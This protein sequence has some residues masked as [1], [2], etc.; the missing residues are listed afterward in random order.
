MSVLDRCRSNLRALES[1]LR[2]EH[3]PDVVLRL[4]ISDIFLANDK[5]PTPLEELEL[6]NTFAT[7][8]PCNDDS[9]ARLFYEIFPLERDVPDDRVRFLAKLSSLALCI[10]LPVILELAAVWLK[11]RVAHLYASTT[12]PA[13]L[14]QP[15]VFFVTGITSDMLS[16]PGLPG[17]THPVGGYLTDGDSPEHPLLNLHHTSPL[18]AE[19]YL[20]AVTLVYG[21][22]PTFMFRPLAAN[23][24]HSTEVPSPFNSEPCSYLGVRRLVVRS[25]SFQVLFSDTHLCGSSSRL[26]PAYTHLFGL[27]DNFRPIGLCFHCSVDT[28]SSPST[29][30]GH[31]HGIGSNAISTN[32]GSSA[33]STTF[34]NWSLS[35]F[36][37]QQ[38]TKD[39]HYLELF[40]QH[41][42][43]RC[44]KPIDTQ[45][46]SCPTS[47]LH[48]KQSSLDIREDLAITRAVEFLQLAWISGRLRNLG[49]DDFTR[50]LSPL[51]EHK[52]IHL[53]L[54]RLKR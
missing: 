15:L 41:V 30:S 44:L 13:P 32:S 40:V 52:L 46:S 12:P 28:T 20:S 22:P 27:V 53:F 17:M 29:P 11:V 39:Y 38:P 54:T 8:F 49:T 16:I 6:L 43:E 2:E 33:G 45:V 26:L 31:R 24:P 47:E 50:L 14:Y 48:L 19:A 7:Y 25:A 4:D 10:G 1:S 21:T 51:A 9:K 18:F 5:K 36:R 35:C 3:K 42:L 23:E 37:K 34:A